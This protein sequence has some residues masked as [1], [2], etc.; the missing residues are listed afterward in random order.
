M[1]DTHCHLNFKAFEGK[2]SHLIQAASQAGVS[3]IVV[4]GTDVNT[5]LKAF[6]IAHE[7]SHVYA[8]AGIH[9]HHVFEIYHSGRGDWTDELRRI[10][11]LLQDEKVIAVGEVG[12]DRHEYGKT[13]YGEYRV[14]E[15]FVRLQKQVLT[16][17]I[18][19]AIRHR[20]TL[21][22]HNRE[23]KLDILEVLESVWKPQLAGHTVLHCCEP[24]DDLLKYARKKHIFIGVDGDVTF[25]PEKEEFVKNIP[26]ELLVLETDSPY[27]LP[28]PLRKQKMYPNKPENIPVIA[29]FIAEKR[30]LGV[31][32]I[33]KQTHAN[34]LHLFGLLP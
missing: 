31:S 16:A 21:I 2:V 24:N 33:E 23:A 17:Q 25:S 11:N 13:K 29:S 9:P 14:D 15:A 30:K 4:P 34:S 3:H 18:E 27:L 12:I 22:L 32:V 7:F 8:A 26:M 19:L 28:E 5:S 20:K 6:E 1:F 10:E